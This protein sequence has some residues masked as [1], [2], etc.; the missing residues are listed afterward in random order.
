MA[1]DAAGQGQPLDQLVGHL[2][3]AF[4]RRAG[5]QHG[6]F[7][8]TQA[9]HGVHLAQALAQALGHFAQ[10]AVARGVAEVVVDVPQLVHV[11]EEQ[12]QRLLVAPGLGHGL[13]HA[14]HQQLP[15]GQVGQ[16]VEMVRR[17]SFCST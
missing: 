1:L 15:V 7:V 2:A 6:E 8:A 16:A 9:G 12:G 14:V 13:G 10:D 5:Q 4:G 11:Q 17:S 3:G